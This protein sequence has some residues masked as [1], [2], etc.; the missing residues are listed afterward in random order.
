MASL[1]DKLYLPE[2]I[3][4]LSDLR[5]HIKG[6][7]TVFKLSK[8]LEDEYHII[9]L[10]WKIHQKQIKEIIFNAVKRNF[11][12]KSNLG[13]EKM[14]QDIS[15]KIIAMWRKYLR[16]EE[17]GIVTKA[18]RKANPPRQSFIDTGDYMRT[19]KVKVE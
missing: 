17:H 3:S 6:D 16:N 8:D 1:P 13:S 14:Y 2:K 5:Q 19:L 4:F 9:E 18:S 11:Y 12:S 15:D 7:I 10:F